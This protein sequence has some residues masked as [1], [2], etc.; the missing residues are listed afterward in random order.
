M[1]KILFLYPKKKFKYYVF[2]RANWQVSKEVLSDLDVHLVDQETLE[3]K[4]MSAS[5]WESDTFAKMIEDS[6]KLEYFLGRLCKLVHF[7]VFA[8]FVG[9][10][11]QHDLR[12]RLLKRLV[13]TTRDLRLL[14]RSDLWRE[15]R[16]YFIA[17]SLFW[18]VSEN[19]L[20][21]I[22][23]IVFKVRRSQIRIELSS[24]QRERERR[25]F[26]LH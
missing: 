11:G 8:D 19:T 1:F 20:L 10:W 17:N 26:R 22:G 5:D 16:R 2:R 15:R 25:W 4:R 7:T 13:V 21:I 24:F 6:Y 23:K 3:S 12:R 9:C 14:R 18:R